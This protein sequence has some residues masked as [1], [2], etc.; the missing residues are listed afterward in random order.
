MKLIKTVFPL[1]IMV[2]SANVLAETS[3]EE[4][5]YRALPEITQIYDLEDDDN[6]GVINARDLCPDT[7]MGAEID[8]DGCGS[9]LESSE[10]KELHILFANNS[11]EINPVFLGQI[12]QMAAFLKRYESTSI[13]LQGYASKV[14]N[15]AHNLKLSKER[16]SHVR[17]ALIS[18][19]IQPSRVNI[20]GHGDSEFSSDD[21]QI[22]HAL[23]RK[24]VASVVGFKGNIKEEWHIFTK[25][26]K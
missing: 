26:K 14:G 11:T 9:Y 20:V 6:D 21:T 13:E 10:K 1:C 3:D 4:F 19:G 7:Q 16:A 8:N 18:N 2:V 22:N 25:I 15:A 17:R 12:R 5:E 23:H 24:V